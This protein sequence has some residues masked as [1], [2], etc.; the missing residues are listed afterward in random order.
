[1]RG[2]GYKCLLELSTFQIDVETRIRKIIQQKAYRK[3]AE[4]QCTI[5]PQF[6]IKCFQ[7]LLTNNI[8]VQV[9]E[10]MKSFLLVESWYDPLFIVIRNIFET[11]NVVNCPESPCKLFFLNK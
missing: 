1:M 6:K 9:H 2:L 3:I 11:F 5:L 8:Y 7:K 10:C 4:K